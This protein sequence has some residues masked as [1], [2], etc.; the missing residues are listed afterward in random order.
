MISAGFAE[1]GGPGRTLQD[2][3]LRRAR[4]AGVGHRARLHG[5]LNGGPE[6]RFNATFSAAFPPPGH[7]SFV[8]QF[9][10][11]GLAALALLNGPS[12]GISGFV[13]VGNTADLTPNDLFL[14][15]DEDPGT[16]VV[17]AYLESVPDPRRF[18]RIARRISGTSRGGG[19][20]RPPG[21]GRRAAPRTPRPSRPG[22]PRSRRCSTRPG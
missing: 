12:L 6:P 14:Y 5:P 20:G 17:L 21:A 4:A 3:L 15:W 22:R 1:V 19:E 16:D 2:E 9:R 10:G 8:T 18:A 7:L 13:S 11:L